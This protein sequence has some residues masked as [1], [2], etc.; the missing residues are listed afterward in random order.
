M[1][2]ED[3]NDDDNEN[4]DYNINNTTKHEMS[5]S[6]LQAPQNPKNGEKDTLVS[7]QTT[8]QQSTE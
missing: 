7:L 8:L 3:D 4:Y 1:E 5:D 2:E 6:V